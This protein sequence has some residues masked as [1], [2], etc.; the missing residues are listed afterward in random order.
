MNTFI[1][2]YYCKTKQCFACFAKDERGV[3][4][5]EYALIGVAMATLLA[6]I[7][8]DQNS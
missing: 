1:T 3:T 2:K 6:F 8:G 7:F 5:I 4:A